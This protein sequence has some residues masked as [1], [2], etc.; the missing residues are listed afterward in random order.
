[1][2]EICLADAVALES[3]Q[4]CTDRS[5][6]GRRGQ[7]LRVAEI[8]TTHLECAFRAKLPYPED[9]ATSRG[10]CCSHQCEKGRLL[11]SAVRPRADNPGVLETTEL[12]IA[13]L[14]CNHQ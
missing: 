6:W 9:N 10:T 2:T 7:L 8:A 1:M 5:G 4:E 3:P 12:D 13:T 11:D 14:F